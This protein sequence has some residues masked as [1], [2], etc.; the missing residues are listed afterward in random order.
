MTG[1]CNAPL[2]GLRPGQHKR[3]RRYA[4]PDHPSGRCALHGSAA[5]GPV[6]EVGKAIAIAAMV[7]GRH[8]WL[9]RLKA[10]G[11]PLTMGRKKGGRNRTPEQI[12]EANREAEG[13]RAVRAMRIRQ[14]AERRGREAAAAPEKPAH[15]HGHKHNPAPDPATAEIPA[16]CAPAGQ[17]EADI[18]EALLDEALA[19]VAAHG[20][21]K[22]DIAALERLARTYIKRLSDWQRPLSYDHAAQ[23]YRRIRQYEQVF[24]RADVKEARLAKLAQA[25]VDFEK[26]WAVAQTLAL[27][28]KRAAAAGL[29]ASMRPREQG[30][31]SIWRKPWRP[32][33]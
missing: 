4:T 17:D 5:T 24:G 33:E 23:L 26:R 16:S 10:E 6:T 21:R 25:F 29:R 2:P 20:A 22:A 19:L 15:R 12:D 8:R 27:L 7:A 9:A 18:P 32:D 31:H 13:R 30:P 3:C 14:N 1:R 28:G 11:K